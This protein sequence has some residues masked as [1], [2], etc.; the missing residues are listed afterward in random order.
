MVSSFLRLFLT[1]FVCCLPPQNQEPAPTAP[2]SEDARRAARFHGLEF[3]DAQLTL[4]GPGLEELR[5]GF[6]RL[7]ALGAVAKLPPAIGY[8]VFMA[9]LRPDADFN[10]SVPRPV[11]ATSAR[12][13][14]IEAL[15]F[16][17]IP[18]LG[19]LLRQG[20]VSCEELA[21]LSLSRLRRLD[22]KLLCVATLC[23]ARALEQAKR[24]DLELAAGKDRGPLHGIPYGAKD[25]LDTGG[26]ATSFGSVIFAGRVPEA[27]AAVIERLDA[28]GAVLVAK[29]SLG[30]LAWGDVWYGGKTKN[31]WNLE[32]GSSG[33]SAG[34]ASAT[35]AGAVVFAIGSETCGSILSP[36]TICGLSSLRPTFGRVSRAGAMELA[37]TMDKIG[38]MCRSIEDVNLVFAAIVGE[39]ARDPSTL[40]QPLFRPTGL[41]A[42]GGRKL[43]YLK[44]AWAA[45]ESEAA[46]LASLVKLGFELEPVALPELPISELLSILTAEASSALDDVTRSGEDERMVRQVAD[47]WPN[48]LRQG[49]LISAVEYLRAQRVRRELARQLDKILAPYDAVVHPSTHGGWLVATNLSGHPTL[50]APTRRNGR[51]QWESLG[52]TGRAF[53]EARLFAVAEVWQR[54][55]DAHL[56]HPD[57]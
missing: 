14:T 13:A 40:G 19:A 47:A 26:V 33:S 32:Q 29:L 22:P 10:G 38:P 45:P 39:D 41:C 54:S 50:C 6:E 15:A 46:V 16:A 27:D 44:G 24:L 1:S 25:L 52:F 23:E 35:A 42:A 2:P 57:L 55:G 7:G 9:G 30:E 21:Q 20:A 18:E 31:P 56:Q 34:P 49:Q 36:S 17:S 51:G 43:G 11:P 53:S 3:T 37:W 5:Q 12:P 4:A 48:V 28:A 8:T